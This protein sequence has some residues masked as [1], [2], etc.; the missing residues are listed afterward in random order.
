MLVP[1]QFYNGE[2][3]VD[4]DSTIFQIE[5]QRILDLYKETIYNYLFNGDSKN[6]KE[7]NLTNAINVDKK[8][9][10]LKK[11]RLIKKGYTFQSVSLLVTFSIIYF[12]FKGIVEHIKSLRNKNISHGS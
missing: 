10:D 8:I 7:D 6:G 4:L 12:T 11:D 1:P 3:E 5:T 2:I 9:R